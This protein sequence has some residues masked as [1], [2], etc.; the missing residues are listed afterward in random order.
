[1][2]KVYNYSNT[3][4]AGQVKTAFREFYKQPSTMLMIEVQTGIMRANLCRYVANWKKLGVIYLVEKAKCPISK[5]M[6]GFY[7][8]NP[9]YRPQAQLKM[10][11]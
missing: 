8:T 2:T 4:F 1:M 3:K 9:K 6:A 10:F 5:M 11:E 7:S